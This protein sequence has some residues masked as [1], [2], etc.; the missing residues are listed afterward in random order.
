MQR[1]VPEKEGLVGTVWLVPNLATQP[2]GGAMA[3]PTP[4]E[5]IRRFGAPF[6]APFNVTNRGSSGVLQAELADGKLIF[7]VIAA[8]GSAILSSGYCT[9]SRTHSFSIDL[10]SYN[11]FVINIALTIL[12][13][14]LSDDGIRLTQLQKS[15]ITASAL[16]GT[17]IGQLSVGVLA[18]KVHLVLLLLLLLMNSV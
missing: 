14:Q 11:L 3:E 9:N 16:I 18:D 6:F 5:I 7:R 2:R 4:T 8:S 12:T 10:H 13:E 17:I 1:Q 15:S